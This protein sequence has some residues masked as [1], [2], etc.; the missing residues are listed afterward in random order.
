MDGLK[1]MGNSRY[2]DSKGFASTRTSAA[3]DTSGRPRLLPVLSVW[4]HQPIREPLVLSTP[5]AI[6]HVRRLQGSLPQSLVCM[7]ACSSCTP[8][9]TLLLR[10]A[11]CCYSAC[12][13]AAT[14]VA[15]ARCCCR[16]R[17]PGPACCYGTHA[18]A[19]TSVSLP[20]HAGLLYPRGPPLLAPTF[21]VCSWNTCNIKHLLQ[22]TSETDE[23]FRTYSCNICV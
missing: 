15:A 4:S 3:Q 9:C 18:P 21:H 20:A 10:L 22:H 7:V 13:H 23:T 2:K 17:R 19:T 11:T 8:A 5:V 16:T 6:S 14:A 12:L 1:P